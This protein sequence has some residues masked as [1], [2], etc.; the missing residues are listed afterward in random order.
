MTFE[1][2]YQKL[3]ANGKIYGAISSDRI[4]MLSVPRI[5]SNILE[6]LRKVED[7]TCEL[8]DAMDALGFCSS[9][10]V[11]P[12]TE[13]PPLVPS[14]RAVGIAVTT[15]SC[16]EQV[17]NIIERSE[18]KPQMF[19]RDMPYLAEKDSIWVVEA[20]GCECSHFCEIAARMQQ[21]RGMVGT[22]V[23]GMIRD[24]ET[25]KATGYPFWCR[26]LT[27]YTGMKRIEVVELN[28]PVTIHNVQVRPGDLVAADGNGICVVPHSIVEKVFDYM[29]GKD[30]C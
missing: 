9:I 22:I 16:P 6:K 30:I 2:Q 7:V 13:I 18:R 5:P 8:S 17:F 26:G 14:Y 11:I 21:S 25:I 4:R 20:R 27:P 24:G 29:R 23:D 1:E 10:S 3:K 28:G 12:A 19:V 15:R